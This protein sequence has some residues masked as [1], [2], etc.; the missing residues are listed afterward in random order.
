M[1][2]HSKSSTAPFKTLNSKHSSWSSQP[3]RNNVILQLKLHLLT[4]IIHL[5]SIND[6]CLG[7]NTRKVSLT[8]HNINTQNSMINAEKCAYVLHKVKTLRQLGYYI[9]SFCKSIQLFLSELL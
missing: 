6:M 4:S 7:R 5:T 3:Q 1:I 8:K 2:E 9:Y